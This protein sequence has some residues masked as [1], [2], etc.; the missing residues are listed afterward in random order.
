MGRARNRRG[1]GQLRTAAQLG[2]DAAIG[3]YL[4]LMGSA[5]PFFNGTGKPH[6]GQPVGIR[7]VKFDGLYPPAIHLP[8][9]IHQDQ[10]RTVIVPVM[11]GQA[12]GW[13]GVLTETGKDIDL[14]VTVY[15]PD[16][17]VATT[18]AGTVLTAGT[19]VGQSFPPSQ[20]VGN[21]L[22]G[23]ELVD[24]LRGLIRSVA[25]DAGY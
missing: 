24:T 16:G 19:T 2:D 18:S 20:R 13:A 3:V 17:E 12:V 1:L 4:I 22:R 21:L 15:A 9:W 7:G 5:A 10:W 11:A 14:P 23:K 8:V 6:P 25:Q